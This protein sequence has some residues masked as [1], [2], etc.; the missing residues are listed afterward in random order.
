MNRS[1]IRAWSLLLVMLA[2]LTQ[3]SAGYHNVAASSQSQGDSRLFQETGH[4]V[5]GRFLSY[6][7]EHGGLTQQ[8]YPLSE[9]LEDV[10]DVDGKTYTA[11]YFERAVFEYHPEN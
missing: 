4:T 5:K 3:A 7:Q 8:G 2:L 1:R 9:E 10:S 11:Q 6:W